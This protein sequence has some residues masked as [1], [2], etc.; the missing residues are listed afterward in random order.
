MT[1]RHPFS[2]NGAPPFVSVI[3]PVWNDAGRLDECLR[4]LEGQTYS[5]QLY[6]VVVVDNDSEEAVGPVV[7]RYG[8]ARCLHEG[9]PGSYAAR[10]A[11]LAHARGEVVAFTDADCLPASDWIEK[12][13]ERL[14]RGGGHLVIA[15]R[16]EIFPR[17]PQR[18]NAVE[19]YEVLFALA[20][21]EFVGRYKFGATANLFAWREAFERVG[22]FLAE[23]RSGGDLE[24]GRRAAAYGYRVEYADETCVRHPA[25]A[26]L[27]QLYSKIVRVTGGLHDLRRIKGRAYLDFDR[28]FLLELLPPVRAVARTLREPSLR[29][30]R[31]RVKVCAMLLFVRYV[32]AFER[33]RLAF[34]KLWSRHTTAR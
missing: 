29:R 28:G 11:G 25:R 31:D 2:E 23:V 13:V 32:Q 21:R 9:R 8:R 3:V 12:G 34:P 15:G 6:E 14:R 30:R 5:G 27:S 4:A 24:W 22:P 7:A 33:L 18:P 19:Q 20:Q 10:N 17:T 16:I 26:S 1:Y